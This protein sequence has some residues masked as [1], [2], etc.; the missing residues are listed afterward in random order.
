MSLNDTPIILIRNGIIIR[1]F[2]T[3]LRAE[4]GKPTGEFSM[5]E[6]REKYFPDVEDMH[7]LPLKGI[8]KLALEFYAE[9][10][11]NK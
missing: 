3:H 10:Q 7:S 6:T 8:A 4:F 1:A 11:T 5:P 9:L 2:P